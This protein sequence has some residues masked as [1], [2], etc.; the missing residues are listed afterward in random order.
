MMV[1][2]HQAY[3]HMPMEKYDNNGNGWYFRFDDKMSYNHILSI[4]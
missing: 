3:I 1:Q 4:T 2:P